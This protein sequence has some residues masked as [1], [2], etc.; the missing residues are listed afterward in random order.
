V[1]HPIDDC[2]HPLL[3]LPLPL[4]LAIWLSLDLLVLLSLTVACLSCKPMCTPGRP[5]L[6]RWNLDM[7]SCGTGCRQTL[8]GSCSRLFLGSCVLMALGRSLLGHE[9][10]QKWWSYLCSQVC[11]YSWEISSL[12]AVFGYR[13]LWHRITSLQ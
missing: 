4:P 1:F 9:F 5:A 10:E 11:L 6:S 8:E 3:Y 12:P 13:A 2:E 7:E